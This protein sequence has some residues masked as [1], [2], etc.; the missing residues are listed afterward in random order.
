M[1][2]AE[3]LTIFGGILSGPVAFFA[4]N[5]YIVLFICPE[6][7]AGMS[8]V[9]LTVF[10]LLIFKML[11]RVWYFRI[12]DYTVAMSL[13]LFSGLPSISGGQPDIFSTMLI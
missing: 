11:G 12:I 9:F 5:S 7:A 3:T 4:F 2:L 13:I 8:N 1:I 10:L 6:V